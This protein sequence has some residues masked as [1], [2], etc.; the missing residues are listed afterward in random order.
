MSGSIPLRSFLKAR[1]VSG[2]IIV[3]IPRAHRDAIGLERGDRVLVET[4]VETRVVTVVRERD[5][6]RNKGGK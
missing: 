1:L 6:F 2:S 4:D 3:V 5:L